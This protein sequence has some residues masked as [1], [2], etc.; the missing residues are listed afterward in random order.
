ML[1]KGP[2]SGFC[3]PMSVFPSTLNP[4]AGRQGAGLNGWMNGEGRE[5]GWEDGSLILL[6]E[7]LPVALA[8]PS[9]QQ[10]SPLS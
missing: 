5:G 2:G 1:I 8:Q 10:S 6:F 7:C 4:L 9:Y 3:P